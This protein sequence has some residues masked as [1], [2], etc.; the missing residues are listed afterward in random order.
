MTQRS[1]GILAYWTLLVA[2]IVIIFSNSTVLT[3]LL[4]LPAILFIYR[5]LYSIHQIEIFSY[6]FNFL[7][8]KIEERF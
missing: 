4:M 1:F 8:D 7:K 2:F 6:S 5:T 3:Q